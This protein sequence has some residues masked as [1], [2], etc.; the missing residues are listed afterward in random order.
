MFEAR[1]GAVLRLVDLRA[2]S[3]EIAAEA[4]AHHPCR[5]RFRKHQ[6]DLA[7]DGFGLDAA[8]VHQSDMDVGVAGHRGCGEP[9]QR[10]AVVVDA[11]VAGH[12]FGMHFA[13]E[14]AAQGNVAADR[15]DV[16]VGAVEG[17]AQVAA[18][19]FD[20]G[21]PRRAGDDH[22]AAH[23]VDFQR[24]C[25]GADDVDIGRDRFDLQLGEAWHVQAQVGRLGLAVAPATAG[26]LG[27]L[28]AHQ[29]VAAVAF[30]HELLDAGAEAAA[31]A[32]FGL[33]PDAHLDAALD[34][35]DLDPAARVERAGLVDG[36]GR[37]RRGCGQAG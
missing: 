19:A 20:R 16:D 10:Q 4:L 9:P 7:A 27:V 18:D 29:Q 32:D 2:G 17:D 33:V 35:L 26:A 37:P 15:L 11:D 14:P 30:D 13:A 31:D 12:A 36:R 21:L 23:A 5:Q 22:V 34:V 24:A 3:V 28:H 1:S 25:G 6:V 8:A